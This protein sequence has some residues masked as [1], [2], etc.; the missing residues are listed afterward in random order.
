MQMNGFFQKGFWAVAV[1]SLSGCALLGS[2]VA[3][4]CSSPVYRAFD[5]WLGEWSVQREPTAAQSN[6]AK[7]PAASSEI[8]SIVQGCAIQERYKTDSGYSGESL[9]WYD[10]SLAKW[11]Q[12]WVDNTGMVLQLAGGLNLQGQMVLSGDQRQDELGQTI[13]DRI[14]WTPQL[15]GSVIQLWQ[16]SADAGKTWEE[17]FR[18]RYLP[19]PAT[20]GPAKQVY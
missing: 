15:D 1:L 14:S 16:S 11:R 19:R 12:T 17:V 5:F 6:A 20:Q 13:Q 18:G 7:M 10:P 9:N 3:E 8:G 4:P 2:G